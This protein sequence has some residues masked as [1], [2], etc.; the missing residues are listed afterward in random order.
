ML[1]MGVLFEEKKL[2]LLEYILQESTIGFLNQNF[3]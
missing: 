3:A 2:S 1:N